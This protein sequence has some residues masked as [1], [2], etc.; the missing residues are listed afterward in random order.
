M[1]GRA[2]RE[3]LWHKACG[4]G[5]SS[6]ALQTRGLRLQKA[7]QPRRLPSAKQTIGEQGQAKTAASLFRHYNLLQRLLFACFG[8]F[9][10]HAE[11]GECLGDLRRVSTTAHPSYSH[12]P[13]SDK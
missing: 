13:L 10:W 7:G 3:I 6:P 2:G 12:F 8:E 1:V 11:A 4:A 5:Q 9:C